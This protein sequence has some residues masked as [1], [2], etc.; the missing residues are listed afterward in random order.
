MKFISVILA[1]V[2]LCIMFPIALGAI[3]DAQTDSQTDT[4]AG[5]VVAA[6]STDVVLTKDLW[7]E[8]TGSVTAITSSDAGASPVA[9]VY[10]PATNTLTITGLGAGTPQDLTVTYDY[11][12]TE[13]FTGLGDLMGLTPLLI[14]IAVIGGLIFGGVMF[15]RSK[16]WF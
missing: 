8:R 5:V 10:N 9:S 4:F 14:W 6:G 12:G 16:G 1:I 13:D 3:H 15:A 7:K 2:V 11:S